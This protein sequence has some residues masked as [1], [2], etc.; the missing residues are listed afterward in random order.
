M[1]ISLGKPRDNVHK[2]EAKKHLRCGNSLQGLWN[3][4]SHW[5]K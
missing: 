5:E 1:Q 4:K 2:I 3:G